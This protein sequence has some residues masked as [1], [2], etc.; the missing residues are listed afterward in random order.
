MTLQALLSGTLALRQ[1]RLRLWRPDQHGVPDA[2]LTRRHAGVYF[3]AIRSILAA[4]MKS[5][6]DSPPIECVV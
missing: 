6:S 1:M 2:A 3:V 5:F 4:Q